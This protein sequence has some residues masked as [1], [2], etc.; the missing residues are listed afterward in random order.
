MKL[1]IILTRP[2]REES[3][4]VQV[5]ECLLYQ[6][7]QGMDRDIHPSNFRCEFRLRASIYASAK[8]S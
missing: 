8:V 2:S 5:P 7:N 3:K 1:S 4:V 6:C